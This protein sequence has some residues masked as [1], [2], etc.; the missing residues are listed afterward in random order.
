[1]LKGNSESTSAQ[2]PIGT[3]AIQ[4]RRVWSQAIPAT[5]DIST[6]QG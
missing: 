5:T 6:A 2:N 4:G 1:M 3:K